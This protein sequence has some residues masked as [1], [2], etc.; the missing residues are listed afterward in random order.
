MDEIENGASPFE[1]EKE[2][3][4]LYEDYLRRGCN[5]KYTG[6]LSVKYKEGRKPM[7]AKCL[8]LLSVGKRLK[9]I[10][11]YVAEKNDERKTCRLWRKK[12]RKKRGRKKE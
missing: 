6:R 12:V 2:I 9:E 4:G 10:D 5:I 8:F 3:H 1:E 7:R 11:R